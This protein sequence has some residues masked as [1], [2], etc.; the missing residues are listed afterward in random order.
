MDLYHIIKI[1]L[2]ALASGGATFLGVAIGN[3][4]NSKANIA[5]GNSFAA[6]IM[7]L[8]SVFELMP[9]AAEELNIIKTILALL[10]G[11]III[12]VLNY[13]VKHIHSVKEITDY[14]NRSLVKLSYLLAIGMILHDFPEGFVI[15]SSFNYS[16]SLGL[17]VVV[18]SFIHN[19]PEGYV[20][21]VVSAKDQNSSFYYKSAFLSSI[22]TFFGAVLGL[23]LLYRFGWINSVL[24][25][26]TAGVM[27]YISF[28]EL[29][30]VAKKYSR[31]YD[32]YLG[33]GASLLFYIILHI[34][35]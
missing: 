26:F 22:S 28:H 9:A 18:A 3:R 30:P 8:I 25:A 20:M 7:I 17:F 2:L 27:L 11:I 24:M 13:F 19:I 34:F 12:F 33:I 15:P 4:V 21:T 16:A 29:L 32:I 31:K 1:L 14:D 23:V 5:F 35:L 6:G 10:L